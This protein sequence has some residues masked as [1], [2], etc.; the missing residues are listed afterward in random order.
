MK[1]VSCGS[2]SRVEASWAFFDMPDIVEFGG[3]YRGELIGGTGAAL[4]TGGGSLI[5]SSLAIGAGAM[6]GKGI[7]ELQEYAQGTQRQTPDEIYGDVATAGAYNALGN[8]IV[9]GAIRTVGKLF[10]VLVIRTRKLFLILWMLTLNFLHPQQK[11]QR[12]R[13]SGRLLEML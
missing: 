6:F 7:D 5:I 4:L 10:E 13:C 12:F 9:G 11:P 3:R 1:A 8:F 2:T